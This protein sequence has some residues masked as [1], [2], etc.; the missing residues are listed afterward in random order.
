MGNADSF[1]GFVVGI[2]VMLFFVG[3]PLLL[4]WCINALFS[5]AI[6]YTLTTWF[7]MLVL[8]IFYP[9]IAIIKGISDV[10]ND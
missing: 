3:I 10:W 4:I 6:P 8:F 5:F 2:L 7:A 9:G 1:A